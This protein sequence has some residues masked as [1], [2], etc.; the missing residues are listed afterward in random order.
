MTVSIARGS[1]NNLNERRKFGEKKQFFWF[2]SEISK[3]PPVKLGALAIAS[4]SKGPYAIV[5]IKVKIRNAGVIHIVGHHPTTDGEPYFE[6]GR[7]NLDTGAVFGQT[8]AACD[9]LTQEVWQVR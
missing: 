3:Y 5:K 8:L 6:P 7:Y 4:P 1:D 9:V 2:F